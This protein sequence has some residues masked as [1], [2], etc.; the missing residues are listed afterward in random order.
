MLTGHSVH[1]ALPMIDLYLPAAHAEHTPPSGPVNP[2]LQVLHADSSVAPVVVVNFANVQ[3]VHAAVPLAILYFPVTHA[4]HGPL[5]VLA[6]P[7]LQDTG[8]A[9]MLQEA[10]IPEP[11]NEESA[12]RDTAK[13]PVVEV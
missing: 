9:E 12:V 11:S 7:A 13:V 2:T 3:S 10:P 6:N 4:V 1:T 8:H 5:F